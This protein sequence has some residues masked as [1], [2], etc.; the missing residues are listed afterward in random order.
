MGCREKRGLYVYG[1]AFLFSPLFGGT[2]REI[3][4]DIIIEISMEAAKNTSERVFLN[5][6]GRCRPSR[7]RSSLCGVEASRS[8]ES[9]ASFLSGSLQPKNRP[10]LAEALLRWS[11]VG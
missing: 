8:G 4:T 11:M 5:T 3:L 6:E 10:E 2:G 7:S 1:E 9:E